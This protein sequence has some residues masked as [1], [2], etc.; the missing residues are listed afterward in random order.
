MY[1]TPRV[2]LVQTAPDFLF[3]VPNTV[4]NVAA[5]AGV[6]V[7]L[8]DNFLWAPDEFIEFI[9]GG[10]ALQPNDAS[11]ALLI[12]GLY[13]AIFGGAVAGG[14]P[15]KQ[16][17]GYAPPTSFSMPVINAPITVSL[18]PSVPIDPRSFGLSTTDP[19]AFVELGVVVQNTDGA[20]PHAATFNGSWI[21]RS[22]RQ[23]REG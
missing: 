3:D 8:D 14:G 10:F 4:E 23:W 11:G 7:T 13:W 22:L 16:Y 2:K 19:N 1:E 20:N 5:G 21:R 9:G 17:L 15:H 12:A 18:Y 6:V